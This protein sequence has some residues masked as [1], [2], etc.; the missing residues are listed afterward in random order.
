RRTRGSRRSRRWYSA[1]RI[2]RDVECAS[3]GTHG[4][5]ELVAIGRRPA[6]GA[7]S[8]RN[9][10]RADERP[11]RDG[12]LERF[13]DD[14]ADRIERAAEG[15]RPRHYQRK[16]I[17]ERARVVLWLCRCAFLWPVIV[18]LRAASPAAQ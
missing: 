8:E 1:R 4:G 11:C 12:S 13:E 9:R 18:L 7:A 14:R 3:C 17:G 16:S 5:H 10:E 6:D 15:R 2:R